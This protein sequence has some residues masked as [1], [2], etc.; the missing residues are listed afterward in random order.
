[1]CSGEGCLNLLGTNA[2]WDITHQNGV[3]IL[4]WAVVCQ[5]CIAR[6]LMAIDLVF[7]SLSHIH[8]EIVK[9]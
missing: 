1:M 5:Y 8:I 9:N 6:V 4:S 7:H 2:I 3:V